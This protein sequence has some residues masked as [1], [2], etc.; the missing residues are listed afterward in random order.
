MCAYTGRQD[1]CGHLGQ[2]WRR[3]ETG[4]HFSGPALARRGGLIVVVYRPFVHD[5]DSWSGWR[6]SSLGKVK[7][8]VGEA[9]SNSEDRFG[10]ATRIR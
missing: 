4:E 6:P 1:S 7:S 5:W 2:P 10:T 8:E 9:A 3:S